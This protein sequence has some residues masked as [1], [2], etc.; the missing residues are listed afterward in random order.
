MTY[1]WEA[2]WNKATT[3][4]F[5]FIYNIIYLMFN[6]LEEYDECNEAFSRDLKEIN[7]DLKKTDERVLDELC[8]EDAAE[9]TRMIKEMIFWSFIGTALPKYWNKANGGVVHTESNKFRRM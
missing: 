8:N 6:S 7:T 4:A 9:N 2:R 5:W 1:I 3:V